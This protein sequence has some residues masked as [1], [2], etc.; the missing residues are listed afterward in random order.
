MQTQVSFEPRGDM[1]IGG[2]S[3]KG[4][5]GTLRALAAAT[6]E[7]LEPAFGCATPAL[8]DR[9]CALAG[10][11]F[12]AYRQLPDA[13]RAAF[14]E[15]IAQ[16]I[17]DLGPALIERAH[18]ETALPIARLEGERMRTVNQLKLFAS[19]VRDGR[20]HGAVVDTAQPQRM[21]LPRPDLRMRRIG[22]GPVAVFGASNFPLAFS[23]AGICVS[24]AA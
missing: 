14:L 2:E 22:L 1:I 3:V 12:D 9:A 24:R 4:A 5:G 19:V 7:A 8:V 6:G 18:L 13:R 16:A 20:W 23:V 11:A 10:A 21:P 15:A 17:L